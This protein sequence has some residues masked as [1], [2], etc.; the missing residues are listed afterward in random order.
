MKITSISAIA[1]AFAMN[2]QAASIHSGLL[3]YWSLDGNGNDT[4][5]DFAESTG[6]TADTGTANGSVSFVG[7]L[8]GSAADLPGGAGNHISVPDGGAS[9]AGGVA[10]DV[11]R[12]GAN[13]T[14]SAWFKVDN[15]SLGW[16]GV[17]AHGEGSDYRIARQAQNNNLGYAGGRRDI[18]GSANV[19]DGAWHHVVAVTLDGVG[20][21]LYVDGVLD[22]SAD[23]SA[24]AI[25][26][27]DDNNN[28]LWIGGN[29]DRGRQFDGQI[30]DVAMW[31][32]GLSDAEVAQIY[33]AGQAGVA[34]G[35]IP[36]PSSGLL[37][38]SG[39]LMGLARRKR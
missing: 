9:S 7:G 26:Q 19:N 20:T 29:P 8:F 14:V 11:D 37:A 4:A 18:T 16:Q 1:A 33:A 38:L 32:R 23:D 27:S 25:A 35:A 31:D 15:F 13:L 30:D 17:V 3:N 2:A 22:A 34:L 6:V 10:N 5:G 39:L 36:E 24:T 21:R 12:T 28:V